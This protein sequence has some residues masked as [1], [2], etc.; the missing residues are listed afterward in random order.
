M[1]VRSLFHIRRIFHFTFRLSCCIANTDKVVFFI[2]ESKLRDCQR[3]LRLK[4]LNCVK[5]LKDITLLN[6][7]E[8]SAISIGANI[9]EAQYAHEKIEFIEKIAVRRKSEHA[10]S[11]KY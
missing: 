8:R 1:I 3:T 6:Q 9:R 7:L 5:Q 10:I 11:R 2:F 4:L